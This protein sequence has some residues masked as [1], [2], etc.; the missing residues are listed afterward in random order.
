MRKNM[1]IN[2]L[3]T[4]QIDIPI[5]QEEVSRSNNKSS[6]FVSTHSSY[7]ANKSL[8]GEVKNELNSPELESSPKVHSRGN[9]SNQDDVRD[10]LRRKF[11]FKEK[12]TEKTSKLLDK[13]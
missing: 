3:K 8:E 7:S 4:N 11:M 2:I 5:S 1:F 10:S 12:E 13:I 9:P 6:E